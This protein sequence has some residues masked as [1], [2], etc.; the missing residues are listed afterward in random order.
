M[1]DKK[2]TRFVLA[3]TAATRVITW[4]CKIAVPLD[5]GQVEVQTVDAKFVVLPPEELARITSPIQA[6]G[7]DS[8]VE[9]LKK[10]LKGFQGLQDERKNTVPDDQAV[11]L[12]L[13]LPYAVRGLV[14]GYLEMAS[15][16][17]AGN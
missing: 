15:G 2:A 11:A 5:D 14:R 8:D 1:S 7:V 12:M 13:S 4:P 16:R 3:S 10:V 17:V 6:P 9:V